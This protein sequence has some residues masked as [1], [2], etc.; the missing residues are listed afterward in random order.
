MSVTVGVYVRYYDTADWFYE[1]LVTSMDG[2]FVDV[3]FADR[4][5]RFPTTAISVDYEFYAEIFVA[6]GVGEV[7]EE[8]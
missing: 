6:N 1:G 4:I 2:A 7:I 8:F 3:D 5:I